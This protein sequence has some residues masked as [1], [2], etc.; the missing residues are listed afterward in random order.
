MSD[1]IN[2]IKCMESRPRDSAPLS[3]LAIIYVSP[4]VRT[5]FDN[6]EALISEMANPMKA[7]LD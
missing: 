7:R 1:D 4:I 5:G 3:F 2:D 6:F